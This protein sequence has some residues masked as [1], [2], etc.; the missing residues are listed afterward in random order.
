[1]ID[2]VAAAIRKAEDFHIKPT[3]GLDDDLQLILNLIRDNSASKIGD[4]FAK[5]AENGGQMSYKRFQ[6]RIVKLS[7]SKFIST[8]KVF[9]KEGNTTKV[10]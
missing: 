7:E 2:H 1:M 3:A 9:G 6:R 10:S 8:Q 4:L 5:Y